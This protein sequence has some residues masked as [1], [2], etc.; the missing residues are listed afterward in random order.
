MIILTAIE[1]LLKIA[2][3][4][5]GYLEKASNS[6]LDSKTANAGKNNYTKYARDYFP[7]LQAQPWCDMFCDWCMIKAFGKETASKM[8]GGF[9]AFTKDSAKRY[10]SMGRLFKT[11]EVGDQIFF[12]NT[13]RICHTG[14]VEKVTSDRVYTCEGNTSS[15]SEVI[16]NGGAVCRKSYPLN[17]PAIAGYGRP[18]WELASTEGGVSGR[19]YSDGW[20]KNDKGWWYV[21]DNKDNYHINNAVRISGKL[22]FFDTEGYCVK[23]PTVTTN[24]K[25]ELDR[26]SGQRVL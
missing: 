21:Y 20:N 2:L 24:D 15:G 25:G 26:I 13:E 4:E 6:N 3:D 5:V 16:P 10:A 22:Y 7:E 1:K 11:P 17:H 18:K 14:W 8:I 23:N 19:K 9:D 12:R